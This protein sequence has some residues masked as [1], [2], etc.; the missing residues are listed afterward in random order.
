[1]GVVIGFGTTVGL[2]F[3]GACATS[4]NWGYNPNAQRL[5]C[6]GTTTPFLTIQ[7]PTQTLTISFYGDEGD[8]PSSYDTT[9]T[10]IEAGSS[11]VSANQ[12]SASVSPGICGTS[13]EG[14][15]ASDWFVTSYSYD[16]SDANVPGIETWSLQRWPS[17]G[18][19]IVAP[20]IVIRTNAEGQATDEGITGVTFATGTTTVEGTTGSVSAGG[21]GRAD[22][23]YYN[24]V[25]SVGGSAGST[26]DIHQ[27]SASISYQ[28]LY[29]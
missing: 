13:V 10:Q 2:D 7:K 3:S 11:C 22:V 18:T 16:K 20:D 25:I 23:M 12:L 24:T 29:Y 28:P 21:V 27:G 9:P 6:L 26:G 15:S 5:Y 14:V 1:M 4:V 17:E 8:G 19:E